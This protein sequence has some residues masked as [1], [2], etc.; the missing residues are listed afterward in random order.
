MN[1]VIITHVQH[2]K[3]NTKY[4]GY[5]PY[6]SEMNIW[7]KYVDN[8]TV[9]A[10][11]E[12]IKLDAIHLDYNHKNL[13][14]KEVQNFNTTSFLNSLQTSSVSLGFKVAVR[15]RIVG[16]FSSNISFRTLCIR[17]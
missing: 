13:K 3:D 8:V 2:I 7:L 5:A 6:V 10:P 17:L 15:P 14:F 4:Y 9:V 1:F 16:H 11:I 12:N